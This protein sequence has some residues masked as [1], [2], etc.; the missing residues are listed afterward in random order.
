MLKH[1]NEPLIRFSCFSEWWVNPNSA[2]AKYFPEVEPRHS[3]KYMAFGSKVDDALGE[4]P[5][6]DWVADIPTYSKKQHQIVT[7]IEGIWVRGS[8][9]SY[10]PKQFK[11]LDNKCAMVKPLKNG[12]WSAHSW[13]Q[14]KV[15]KHEQLLFYSTLVQYHHGWVDNECHI[16]VVPYFEDK[17]ETMR[18]VPGLDL[19]DP[20]YFIPRIVTQKERD[21]MME[22][23][24]K[25]SKEIIRNY[26]MWCKLHENK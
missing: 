3:N 15:D 19:Y 10:C 17:W 4:D 25:T 2:M 26:D 8:L 24:I 20:K 13:T 22:K 23:I 6:P 18:R 14:D 16:S 5:L 9:D 7:N 11:F 12:G 1:N 21:K